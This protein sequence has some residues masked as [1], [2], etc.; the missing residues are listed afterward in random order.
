M[1]ELSPSSDRLAIVT[2]TSQGIGEALARRLLRRGWRVVGISRRFAAI[3]DERYRHLCVDLGDLG[4]LAAVVERELAASL[5][6]RGVQRIGLINN[7]AD[8]GRLARFEHVDAA[9]WLRLYATNVVAP[10]WLTAF[11]IRAGHGAAALRIVNVSS[12]AAVQAYPG[13]AD[14]SGSKAALRISGMVLGAELALDVR[15]P[16]PPRD[17]SILSYEPGA[18]DT[19]MQALAR[20]RPLEVFP[21]AEQFRAAAPRL[22]PPELPAEE[23]AAYLEADGQPLYAERRLEPPP[24]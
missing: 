5:S 12:A 13:L 4:Q 16:A 24:R 6:D 14:Y 21:L 22:V 23:I 9:Q 17:V 10:L 1:T 20:S 18:V 15:S 11:V 19:A 2:G 8:P 7:A 3:E